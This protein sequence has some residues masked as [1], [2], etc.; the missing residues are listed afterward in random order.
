M[1]NNYS[2]LYSTYKN[3][4]STRETIGISAKAILSLVVTI[5][6]IALI[7]NGVKSAYASLTKT[8]TKESAEMM[9]VGADTITEEE[10]KE[11]QARCDEWLKRE[12]ELIPQR[13][14]E[15]RCKELNANFQIGDWIK[16]TW[17]G[18]I[19]W[20]AVAPDDASCTGQIKSISGDKIKGTWGD[21]ELQYRKAYF[22]RISKKEYLELREK[23]QKRRDRKN[24][25]PKY[26]TWG[27]RMQGSYSV[28]TR[29]R[30]WWD[31]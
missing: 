5:T 12:N 26:K 17:W 20:G 27:I 15:E 30:V 10:I 28:N 25:K 1:K 3:N 14:Y 23:E 19:K 7:I 13:E 8:I 29:E 22:Q 31:K 6:T 9:L 24:A 18:D 21:Y 2:K 4:I 11:A 16:I